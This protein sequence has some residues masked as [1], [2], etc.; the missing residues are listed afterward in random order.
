LALK[1]T[2]ANSRVFILQKTV[3]GRLRR[4]TLGPYGDLTLDMARAQARR[5][6]GEIASGRDP[7]GEA[8]ARREAKER[9]ARLEKTMADLWERYSLEVVAIENKPSTAAEKRRLWAKR[10]EP[11]IGKQKV[12]EVTGDDVGGIVRQSLRL[13]RRGR[14]IGGK[15]EAGNVYRLLNHMFHKALVWGVR[16]RELGNPLEA[17][18]EPKTQRRERLLAAGEVGA[19]MSALDGCQRDDLEHPQVI[20]AI[21]VTLL[22]G[23]RVSEVLGLEWSHIHRDGPELHLPDTKTGFSRR[24]LS[25]E[26]IAVIDN[27][28]RMPGSAYVFRSPKDPTKPV[29]YS[30]VEQAFRRIR[31]RAG[32]NNC[33]LHTL[34]HW[35]ATLT[36]NSVSNPRIGMALTGHKSLSAYM[37]YVHGD[38]E[39]ARA[40]ADQ[41]G[42]FS[43]S[44]AGG[45]NIVQLRKSGR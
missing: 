15:G 37:N 4:I 31:D 2:P 42:A 5:L 7:V 36:A 8:K 27:V 20:A 21:K 30:A 38:R 26:A 35:F 18:A 28:G 9:Q 32:V 17:V 10:I 33:T 34:R 19:I 1:I 40:L 14:V 43:A 11:V 3:Q 24:P 44:L 45:G 13:D 22:I 29:S 39:Q 25:A 23:A 41:L 6:N 12:A 16:P